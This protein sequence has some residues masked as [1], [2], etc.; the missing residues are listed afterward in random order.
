HFTE[1][2]PRSFGIDII[3]QFSAYIRYD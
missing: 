2:F 3:G 1:N